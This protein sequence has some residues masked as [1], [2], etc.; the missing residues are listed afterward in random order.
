MI[1]YF[2]IQQIVGTV[3]DLAI[4]TYSRSCG[5]RFT[6]ESPPNTLRLYA[7]YQVHVNQKHLRCCGCQGLL[8]YD[9]EHKSMKEGIEGERRCSKMFGLCFA[10]IVVRLM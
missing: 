6:C 5:R 3:M 10:S 2:D 8:G 1:A 4:N 7:A 9:L